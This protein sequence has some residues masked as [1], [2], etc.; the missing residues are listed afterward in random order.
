MTD[1][2]PVLTASSLT[3]AEEPT[4]Y[5]IGVTTGRSSIQRVFPQWARALG[6]P[7]VRLRGID[8]PLHAPAED[9]RAVVE[10]IATDP[11]S[12][13]GLVT[14]HKI[15][16]FTACRD[17]FDEIDP[18]AAL[19]GETSCLSKSNGRLVCHAKDPISS[20]LAMDAFIPER[21][22]AD[23]GGQVLSLGAGGSTIA[24]AWHLSHSDRA[25]RPDRIV[26]TNRSPQRLAHLE[27]VYAQF[28]TDVPLETVLA[29]S[30]V[31]NDRVLTRMPSGSLVVN[32]TG[33]GKDAPGSPLTDDARFPADGFAWELNYRGELVFLD[34]ARAQAGPRRLRIEDGWVYFLHGW[35]RVIAEVLHEDVPTAGPV[36]DDLAMLA[37]STR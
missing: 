37:A 1:V 6:R 35:T 34:Q 7:D 12:L 26:V 5:F 33:L 21:H 28:G 11:L 29:P 20:G 16:L 22:W 13:G 32:A 3:A 9:Y 17:L 24:I 10:F 8:L 25:D 2:L 19:M 31:D 4:L 18:L 30:P 15:D 27:H 36:F 23:T 14:T